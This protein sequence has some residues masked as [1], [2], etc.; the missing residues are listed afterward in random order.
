MPPVER[1]HALDAVLERIAF[2]GGGATGIRAAVAA[3]AAVASLV[4]GQR[5]TM[6]RDG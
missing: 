3:V 5:G 4:V 6:G 1:R 2:A